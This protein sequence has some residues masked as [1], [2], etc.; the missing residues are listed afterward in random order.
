MPVADDVQAV[1]AT[2]DRQRKTMGD[3]SSF[4][5]LQERIAALSPEDRERVGAHQRAYY[6]E[7]LRDAGS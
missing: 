1:I 3:Y 2:I 5:R 6:V 4:V 7:R